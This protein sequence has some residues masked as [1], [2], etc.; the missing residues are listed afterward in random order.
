MQ[1]LPLNHTTPLP[2]RFDVAP[3]Y[4]KKDRVLS[5]IHFFIKQVFTECLLCARH[6][7]AVVNKAD[8]DPDFRK[9]IVW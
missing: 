2:G 8:K 1:V 6:W 5:F 7:D 3:F 9:F 4:R